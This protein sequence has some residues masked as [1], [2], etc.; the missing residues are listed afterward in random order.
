MWWTFIKL[1]IEIINNELEK[2]PNG[3]TNFF[4][5]S[6]FVQISLL[7]PIN[8]TYDES[9]INICHGIHDYGYHSLQN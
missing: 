5:Y 4:Y 2:T 7:T 9:S 8:R 3:S 6:E 1:N